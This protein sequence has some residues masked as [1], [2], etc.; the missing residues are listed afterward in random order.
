MKME[1]RVDLQKMEPKAYQSMLALEQY[2]H[3]AELTKAHIHLLKIRASQIN[4]CAFCIDMHTA[5]ALKGGESMQRIFLLNAWKDSG[6]F[7]EEEGI[8]L[9]MTEE[10]T[11]IHQQGLTEETYQKAQKQWTPRYVA[12]V[13]MAIVTINA[14]NRIAIST[15]KRVEKAAL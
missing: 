6:L 13:I 4:G 7:S 8:L 11:L 10:I 1:P 12:Q 5:E 15:H 14:W 3:Q 2:L 9:A